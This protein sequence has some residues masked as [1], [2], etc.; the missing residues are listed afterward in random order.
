ML[1]NKTIKRFVYKVNVLKSGASAAGCVG[2]QSYTTQ[3]TSFPPSVWNNDYSCKT[4][5]PPTYWLRQA[6]LV[7]YIASVVT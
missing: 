5:S 2:L 7:L 3:N 1:H 6:L 4:W